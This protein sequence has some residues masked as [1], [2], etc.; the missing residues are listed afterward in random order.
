MS[1]LLADITFDLQKIA[2]DK[3]IPG[4]QQSDPEKG[5]TKTVG[6]LMQAAMI[7]ASLMLLLNLVW[8]AIEWIS[9]GGDSSKIEKARNKITQ[10]VIGIIVLASSVAIF[11]LIQKMLGLDVLSF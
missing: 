3:N 1:N 4:S 7:I 2:Q 5:F 9:S 11:M 8:G 6:S 10:S